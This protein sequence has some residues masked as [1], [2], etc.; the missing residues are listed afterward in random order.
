MHVSV[1][2]HGDRHR[3]G[4]AG[5]HLRGLPTRRARPQRERGGHRPRTHALQA[6]RRPSRWAPV[7]GERAGRRQ[8]VLL[9]DP[10][11]SPSRPAAPATCAALSRGR[12]LRPGGRGRPQLRRPAAGLP[13]GRRLRRR[14]RARRRRGTRPCPPPRAVRRDPRLLLAEAQRLG[15]DRP[16]QGRSCD[17]GRSARDRVDARRAGRRVRARARPSTSSSRS[18]AR[19]LLDALSHCMPESRER[20]RWSRSTRPGRPGPA[21]GGARARGLGVV[22]ATGGEEG[23]RA[24]RRERPAVV[25]L[26]LLMPGVDGFAVVEQ[27]RADPLVGD[28][29]IV[30]LTSKE[31]T[32]ADQRA[33]RRARSAAWRG[34]GRAGRPS[35]STSSAAS[36]GRAAATEGQAS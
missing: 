17:V 21:R 2:R 8:H 12:R 26:D 9:L 24:V 6:A 3:R 33:A 19:Q 25:V 10:A 23:V 31:M 1:Q 18:I 29:P 7:D 36:P 30:V 22:R 20:A 27:L 11:R 28:V 32:R 4:R 5:A 14:G 15:A 34:R 16:A 35:W 13:R